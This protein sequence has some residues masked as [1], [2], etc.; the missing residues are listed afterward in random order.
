[1]KIL[2]A[3]LF[4]IAIGAGVSAFNNAD[5]SSLTIT[6]EEPITRGAGQYRYILTSDDTD[7]LQT[8]GNWVAVEQEEAPDCSNADEI[9]CFV[10]YSGSDFDGFLSTATLP[11][12][13]G[14]AVET[15]EVVE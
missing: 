12:L 1:M 14:I 6:G 15:K 3:C 9:P 11:A 4:A 2:F 10:N 13:M 5:K 8:P 7:K